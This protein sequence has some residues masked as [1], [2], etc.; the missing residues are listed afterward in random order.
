M[1]SQ[2]LQITSLRIGILFCLLLF[3]S[4]N[5]LTVSSAPIRPRLSSPGSSSPTIGSQR[6]ACGY[7][8]SGAQDEWIYHASHL[9]TGMSGNAPQSS[10]DSA[11]GVEDFGD[12]AVITDDGTI[13]APPNNFD[14]KNKTVIFEP[15]AEGYR[16]STGGSV[17][18][19]EELGSRLTDFLSV[20]GQTADANNGYVEVQLA[21]APFEFFGQSYN[22]VYV[23]TNGYVTFNGGDTSA[24]VSPSALASELPRIAPLWSDLDASAKGGIYYNRVPGR[25][26][27]TWNK[28]PQPVYSGKSTF[29]LSLYD[30][31]RIAFSFKKVQIHAALTGISPGSTSMPQSISFADPP[32][33]PLQG[34]LFEVF[35]EQ[36]R[37][38]L[39]ALT[40]A[41]Y[42]AHPDDF[43]TIY[44]WTDFSYDNGL[45]IA[46]EF[47]IR[48]DIRGIG[49]PIYDRGEVYGS[50]SRLASMIT[51]GNTNDWPDDPQ[52]QMAGLN[53]AIA[54]VCHE[55]GHRWLAYVEADGARTPQ[56]NLLGRDDSHWSFFLDTRTRDDGNYSSLMEG[57]TWTGFANGVFTSSETM[58]NFFSPLDQ[59]LMGLRSPDEVGDIFYLAADN[60]LTALLREKSP[61]SGFSLSAVRRKIAVQRIIDREGPREPDVDTAPK[62]FRIAFVLLEAKGTAPTHDTLSKISDYREALI[63]YFAGATG[64]R[65][66]LDASLLP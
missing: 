26:L 55:F 66:S 4:P 46:H 62:S 61:L 36:P 7:D 9:K 8:P 10:A 28:L 34:A 53:S 64:R 23:G 39:P 12:T 2:R 47:N 16:V 44:V 20:D 29:Q 58:V 15:D 30:D 42:N 21:S 59:Y 45:G 60:D 13:V 48:N 41:F 18:Y 31:G 5:I 51:M 1:K 33:E 63:R 25:H 24:R 11:P 17:A 19:N 27:I 40:R 56:D 52:S 54:I 65:A 14:L 35:T 22:K 32:P 38:D 43:D 3:L 49:L 50:S 57:N 6:S 37:L